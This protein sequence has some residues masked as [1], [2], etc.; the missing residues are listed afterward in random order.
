MGCTES[1]FEVNTASIKA[2]ARLRPANA[3]YGRSG[4]TVFVRPS[5][6]KNVEAL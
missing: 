5:L 4:S 6:C 1:A 3:D 2:A